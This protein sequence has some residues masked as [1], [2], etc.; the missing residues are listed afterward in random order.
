MPPLVGRLAVELAFAVDEDRDAPRARGLRLAIPPRDGDAVSVWEFDSAYM[1]DSAI[2]DPDDLRVAL[3]RELG[4]ELDAP[5]G[6]QV[7]TQRM[8]MPV[9]RSRA[10]DRDRWLNRVIELAVGGPSRGTCEDVTAVMGGANDMGPDLL[11]GEPLPAREGRVSPSEHDLAR[12]LDAADD[13]AA[14]RLGPSATLGV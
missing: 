7:S 3:R 14:V 11:G 1:I 12:S 4:A 5:R 2:A 10:E 6:L 9:V 8:S 13:G